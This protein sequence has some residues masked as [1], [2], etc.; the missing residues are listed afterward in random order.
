MTVENITIDPEKVKLL[1]EPEEVL[2]GE[3]K[4]EKALDK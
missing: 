4:P 1:I 3:A 2:E